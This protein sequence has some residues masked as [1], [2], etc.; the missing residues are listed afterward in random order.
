[1]DEAI[2]VVIEIGQGG[3]HNPAKTGGNTAD[4]AVTAATSTPPPNSDWKRQVRR[5]LFPRF[6]QEPHLPFVYHFDS[7]FY[8]FSSLHDLRRP[9]PVSL[10]Y[11]AAGGNITPL[12]CVL[13]FQFL[14]RALRDID[15]PGLFWSHPSLPRRGYTARRLS[16]IKRRIFEPSTGVNSVST[17]IP[18]GRRKKE[19][20]IQ[21]TLVLLPPPPGTS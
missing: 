5:L 8:C 12:H 18:R 3:D 9:S 7:T 15:R 19:R 11:T 17:R 10:T 14:A 20:H 21:P 13:I 1:M 6:P 16:P 4:S 2:Q